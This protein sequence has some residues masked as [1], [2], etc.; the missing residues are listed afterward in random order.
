M[1]NL[2]T[3]I[4]GWLEWLVDFFHADSGAYVALMNTDVQTALTVMR[5]TKQGG[6]PTA[7][8]FAKLKG[9]LALWLQGRPYRDIEARLGVAAEAIKCCPR[10]RDL[11]LKLTSRRLYLIMS[12]V[13]A[14]AKQLYADREI[15]S[16]QPS[17][18]ETLAAAIRKGL[19]T[20]QKVAYD[21]ASAITRSRVRTHASFAQD[22]PNPPELAGQP[23]EVVLNQIEM[24]MMFAGINDVAPN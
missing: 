18:L 6:P 14:I 20:P 1:E 10:S 9:A 16:P 3:S 11:I 15:A 23:Y 17:V 7:A 19:D 5:G 8:E 22:I 13:A 12:A 24:R 2:P 21:Q 4:L